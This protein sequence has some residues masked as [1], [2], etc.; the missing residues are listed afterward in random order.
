MLGGSDMLIHQY[1]LTMIS[2]ALLR[3]ASEGSLRY[4]KPWYVK[5]VED[6]STLN[7]NFI[8][9]SLFY[10]AQGLIVFTALLTSI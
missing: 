5:R 4:D 10:N 3:R 9:W 6:K 2:H 1:D 8:F 7:S